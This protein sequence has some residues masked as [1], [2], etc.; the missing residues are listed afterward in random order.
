MRRGRPGVVATPEALR[1]VLR[2]FPCDSVGKISS[3][4]TAMS[5]VAAVAW[6]LIPGLGTST[7]CGCSQKTN[8]QKT[9]ILS[10]VGE[11]FC[12]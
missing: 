9:P 1:L 11:P 8:K 12:Q 6:G 3:V 5:W 4:V 7:C 10:E 2:E